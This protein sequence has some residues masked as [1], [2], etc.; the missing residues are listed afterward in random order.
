MLMSILILVG[1]FLLAM[2]IIDIKYRKIPSFFLTAMI[3]LLIIV[4]IHQGPALLSFGIAGFVF[5]WLL[6][7]FDYIRGIA[8]VKALTIVSLTVS[9]LV[10][11]AILMVIIGMVGLMYQ[12]VALRFLNKEVKNIKDF[13]KFRDEVPFIPAIFIVYIIFWI[14]FL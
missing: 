14:L 11:F 6:Y 10:Q 5:A 8:D 12:L 13:F 7:D 1:V 3:L 4:N 2:A 9:T